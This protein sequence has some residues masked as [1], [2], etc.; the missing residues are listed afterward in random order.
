[1]LAYSTRGLTRVKYALSLMQLAPMFRFRLKKPILAVDMLVPYQRYCF[2][3][4]TIRS[5]WHKVS[6]DKH[7]IWFPRNYLP[8]PWG[9]VYA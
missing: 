7:D 6:F 3:I 1:M 4:C 9:N 2:N 8:L 5:K